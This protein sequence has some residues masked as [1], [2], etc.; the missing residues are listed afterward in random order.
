MRSWPFKRDYQQDG[1][2]RASSKINALVEANR[3][4]TVARLATPESERH[5]YRSQIRYISTT[6]EYNWMWVR[7]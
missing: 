6:N 7:K 3:Q 4:I 2:V 5:L 1:L